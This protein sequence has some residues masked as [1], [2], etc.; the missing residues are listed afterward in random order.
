MR[1]LMVRLA[2]L[3]LGA[4]DDGS[5]EPGRGTVALSEQR[6]PALSRSGVCWFA[7]YL[8]MWKKAAAR[9][10]NGCLAPFSI[11]AVD[12]AFTDAECQAGPSD[13]NA[14]SSRSVNP[15]G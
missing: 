15:F 8:A 9:S 11:E 7:P 13:D 6:V 12:V 3:A 2:L 14:C 1:P 4:I 5:D 10:A